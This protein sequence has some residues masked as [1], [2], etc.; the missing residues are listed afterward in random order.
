MKI[1]GADVSVRP[2][3][4]PPKQEISGE[5]DTSLGRTGSSAPTGLL[6]VGADAHIGPA[7]RTVFTEIF[8]KSVIAQW[9]DVGIDPYESTGENTEIR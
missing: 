7:K 4:N 6:P 5:F 8:R 9:V 1:V 2:Q 3:K